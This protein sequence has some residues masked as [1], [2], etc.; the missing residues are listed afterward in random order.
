MPMMK[1]KVIEGAGEEKEE[2]LAGVAT[3]WPKREAEDKL[4]RKP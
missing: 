2:Q 4:L 3:D 1:V